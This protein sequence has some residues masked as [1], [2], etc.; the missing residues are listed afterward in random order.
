[1]I[2]SFVICFHTARIDNMLQTL[3]FL[4]NDHTEVIGDCYFD[5]VCQDDLDKLPT[6]QR[7]ELDALCEK[8]HRSCLTSLNV[9]E[10]HL[11]H[12]TNHAIENAE[13]DKI[14]VLESDRILPKGYFA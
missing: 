6:E 9:K 10:M 7:E 3:R 2:A 14:V 11:P 5:G 13:T 1:M 8:F 4:T 12:L